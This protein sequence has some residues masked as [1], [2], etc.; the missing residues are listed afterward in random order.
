MTS[1]AMAARVGGVRGASRLP[2][3]GGSGQFFRIENVIGACP[4]RALLAEFY[5]LYAQQTPDKD[6]SSG[7]HQLAAAR[8][9]QCRRQKRSRRYG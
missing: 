2:R 8:L 5:P 1:R 3:R 4:R 9:Q 7:V 6:L